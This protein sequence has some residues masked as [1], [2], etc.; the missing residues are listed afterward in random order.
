MRPLGIPTMIDRAVQAVY[1]LGVD[2]AVEAR[3]DK[4][5]F[6][7]RKSRSTH[8]AVTAIRMIMDKTTHPHWIVEADITKCFDRISHEFLMKET[9]IRHKHVLEQWLK[10]GIMEEL[11]FIESAEGTPQ[12]GI[13][14]PT[15]CNIALN[16]LEST[17]RKANPLI[18]GITQGVNVIRY[19]DDMIITARTQETAI[20]N[21]KILAEFLSERG[22]ELNDKKTSI[23]HI[24]KGFDFLGFN[25]KR[26]PKDSRF[27]A[28]TNQ[29]TVL[30]IKPSKKGITK[31]VNNIKQSITKYKPIEKIIAD[32]NP[33]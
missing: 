12:G 28:D 33:I 4:N 27:N 7:F 6:G 15:L 11:N 26:L 22:L 3:S 31:L 13:M 1:H 9:P 8:D 18:K 14:S 25:F 17:I 19:A 32:L 30:I 5:S 16:G 23:T 10:A 2:P 24:K 20:K 29:E 21:K